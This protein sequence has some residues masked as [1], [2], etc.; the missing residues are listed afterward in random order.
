MMYKI[1][2]NS[3]HHQRKTFHFIFHNQMIKELVFISYTTCSASNVTHEMCG[4]CQSPPT[5]NI[6]LSQSLINERSLI[7]FHAAQN[8]PE[9]HCCCA[10]L[11]ME[12]PHA[13]K[14]VH[15]FIINVINSHAMSCK[16]TPAD[17]QKEGK[18]R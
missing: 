1:K 17:Y 7:Q 8:V 4:A 2:K 13:Q 15:I 9:T 12:A 11:L 18:K 5:C 6:F 3:Y 10:L 14:A 16:F